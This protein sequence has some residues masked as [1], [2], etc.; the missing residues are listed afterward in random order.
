MSSLRLFAETA[1]LT[2]HAHHHH[3]VAVEQVPLPS[4]L[5]SFICSVSCDGSRSSSS[6]SQLCSTN[7]QF[8]IIPNPLIKGLACGNTDRSSRLLGRLSGSSGSQAEGRCWTA[9]AHG[10]DCGLHWM[11]VKITAAVNAPHC[12]PGSCF[13]NTYATRRD[14]GLE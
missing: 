2:P 6:S 14:R 9:S 7:C 11:R 8:S 5:L 13:C 4:F 3:T 10:S 1:Q 12:R